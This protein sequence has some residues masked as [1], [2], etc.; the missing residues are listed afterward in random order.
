MD[1]EK[2]TIFGKIWDFF[3]KPGIKFQQKHPEFYNKHRDLIGST[4]C[5]FIGAIITYLICSFMPYAFGQR[6]AEMEILIPDIDMEL[7][8]IKYDWSII[9][10][11]IRWRDGAAII[12]G[13]LGYSISYYL[14]N[15]LSHLASFFYMR[16]FHKSYI[17]PYKQYFIGLGFCFATTII[18][19]M[20]NGLWL[21]IINAKL[22]F[23]EYNIIV[24]GVIGIVN[25][26]IGHFQ[27]LIIYKNDSKLNKKILEKDEKND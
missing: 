9:G 3:A 14:A 2:K 5:G 17:N 27:N 6:F 12:G 18:T 10:F 16:K 23:I 22:T 13:G 20:I 15:Y 11:A 25:F 19:N 7:A 4:I 1:E 24:L 26:I 21:P 8:G